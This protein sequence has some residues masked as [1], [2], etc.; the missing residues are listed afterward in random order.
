MRTTA[1]AFAPATIANLGPGFDV[2]GM[3]ISG[4]GDIVTAWRTEG[5]GVVLASVHG[6]D[7]RL[8]RAA[9]ENTA[10]I[11]AFE[12]LRRSGIDCGV[13]LQLVKGLP[14]GS[15]LGS[16]AASAAAAAFAVNLLLGSPLRRDELLLPCV[17]AEAAVSGRHADN[18][19]PSLFGGLILVREI[20]P[21]D[22]VRLPLPAR[23][24]VVVV[25]PAFE[26]STRAARRV[27]P[28]TVP[29]GAMVKNSANIAA[30]VTACQTGNLGLLSRAL[31]DDLI[32][33]RRA[34]LVPGATLAMEAARDA[35]ALG[36]GVSGSGPTLFALC[37]S[38]TSA[39]EVAL[40]METAFGEAGLET[41]THISPVLC[42]G[43]RELHDG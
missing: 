39:G 43:A 11:A 5:S 4:A 2:L 27:L 35:G 3:A 42:P 1:C 21:P 26:I 16:S 14:M 12:T 22:L 30:L 33:P 10:G 37:R 9:S 41:K 38:S 24:V 19:A 25:T 29:I 40:A 28:K 15:G 13:E 31:E 32:A 6:D 20:D 34:E 23:L 17:E 18:V 36:S 7:G 8:P